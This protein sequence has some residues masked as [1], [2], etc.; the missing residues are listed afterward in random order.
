[1]A[2]AFSY[3][4]KHVYTGCQDNLVRKFATHKCRFVAAM[5]R[6]PQSELGVIVAL[7]CQ[8]SSDEL[9]VVSRSCDKSAIVLDA[10]KLGVHAT[11]PGHK[12]MIW[13]A[14]YSYDDNRLITSC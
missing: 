8:H 2:V 14:Q 3:D 9:L 5:D 10:E 1:T 13:Q 12:S 7:C 6:L 11:L 4:G